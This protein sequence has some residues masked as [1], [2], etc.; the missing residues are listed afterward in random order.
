MPNYIGGVG[1]R[2]KGK[3]QITKDRKVLMMSS[4]QAR[5]FVNHIGF[6]PVGAKHFVVINPPAED[7]QVK[8]QAR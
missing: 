7:F 4:G 1:K 3:S 5:I 6:P 8:T 2:A